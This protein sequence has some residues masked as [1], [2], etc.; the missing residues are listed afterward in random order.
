MTE[1]N[2]GSLKTLWADQGIA[3]GDWV[4]DQTGQ[5]NVYMDQM[6]DNP[7]TPPLGTVVVADKTDSV[8][9]HAPFTRFTCTPV[10][11]PAAGK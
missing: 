7:Q 6:I 4:T 8:R 5:A 11:T 9:G 1:A 2:F 3:D 10:D